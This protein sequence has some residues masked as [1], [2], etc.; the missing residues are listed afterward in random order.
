VLVPCPWCRGVHVH[1][2]GAGIHASR[3]GHPAAPSHYLLSCSKKLTRSVRELLANRLLA[4][5]RAVLER[6]RLPDELQRVMQQRW[7]G[8]PAE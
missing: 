1:Q 3:C 4:P 6:Q 2:Y 7:N 5:P 8:S